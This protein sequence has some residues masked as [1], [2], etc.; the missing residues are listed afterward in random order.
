VAAGEE[1]LSATVIVQLKIPV[2]VGA[3]TE[4]FTLLLAAPVMEPV[5]EA[6]PLIRHTDELEVATHFKVVPAVVLLMVRVWEAGV[7]A[8][9][10][11]TPVKVVPP[12]V[13]VRLGWAQAEVLTGLKPNTITNLRQT[14]FTLTAAFRP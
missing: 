11:D 6:P 4:M 5:A 3:V 12:G 2:L 1:P 7:A 13:R 14:P 8:P 10:P 9:E